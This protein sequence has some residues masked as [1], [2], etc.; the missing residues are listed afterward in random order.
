MEEIVLE[1]DIVSLIWTTS[2]LNTS[3]SLKEQIT[4]FS[5]TLKD[6]INA[7]LLSGLHGTAGHVP[8]N[9]TK[10]VGPLKPERAV[11]VDVFYKFAILNSNKQIF[12]VS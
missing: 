1:M 4:W 12:M 2:T 11:R 9:R 6:W 10:K 5:W 8:G 3:S 7:V